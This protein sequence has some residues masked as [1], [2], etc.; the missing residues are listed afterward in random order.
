MP[1]SFSVQIFSRGQCRDQEVTSATLAHRHSPDAVLSLSGLFAVVPGSPSPLLSSS[2]T[3]TTRRARPR[4]TWIAAIFRGA[5]SMSSLPSR[6]VR[7]QT[8][9][10]PAMARRHAAIRGLP[11][12]GIR[13]RPLA[14]VTPRLRAATARAIATPLRAAIAIETHR[15]ATAMSAVM[16]TMTVGGGAIDC[17]PG[18]FCSRQCQ[19]CRTIWP[20]KFGGRSSRARTSCF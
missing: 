13:A 10:A 1:V 9:C 7:A 3:I 2:S 12:G 17:I 20:A 18:T 5:S 14:A 4:K 15:A 8:R 19:A 6:S 16:T 11:A